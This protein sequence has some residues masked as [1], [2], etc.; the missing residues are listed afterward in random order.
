ME[1]E[2][3][4]KKED[5]QGH[6]LI[7]K[8]I[9]KETYVD[10]ETNEKKEKN[11][12]TV[13]DETSKKTVQFRGTGVMDSQDIDI[14]TVQTIELKTS[15][16]AGHHQYW[17]FKEWDGAPQPSLHPHDEA[18]PHGNTPPKPNPSPEDAERDKAR[19]KKREEARK[20]ARQ[21]LGKDP[22]PELEAQDEAQGEGQGE[23]GQ[24]GGE[25]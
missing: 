10:L 13:Y 5:L 14:G 19:E 6:K 24:E 20:L 16:K 8:G 9:Q 23:E 15:K 4:Q 17:I 25:Q 3:K 1:P 2:K 22:Q 11:V 21:A 12:Y 18:Q 7:I